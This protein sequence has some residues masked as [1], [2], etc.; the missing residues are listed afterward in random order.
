MKVYFDIY[1]FKYF[2]LTIIM[3]SIYSGFVDK[4]AFNLSENIFFFYVSEYC[5]LI[6]FIYQKVYESICK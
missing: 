5:L 1:V 3:L 2:I 6:I 4:I